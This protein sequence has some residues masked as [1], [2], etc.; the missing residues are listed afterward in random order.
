MKMQNQLLEEDDCACFLVEAIA[1]QSQNIEWKTTIDKRRVAH[2]RIR[3]V[4]IDKFYEIVTGR[5]DAFLQICLALPRVVQDV[6]SGQNSDVAAPN[7]T[8]YEQMME[9]ARR[10]EN[11]PADE[12]MIMSMYILGFGTYNGFNI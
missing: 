9:T 7:D 12:A 1:K 11:L 2:A 8:V 3:R 6:L 4:S 5:H 10:F